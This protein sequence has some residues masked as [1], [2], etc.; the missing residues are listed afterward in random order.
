MSEYLPAYGMTRAKLD[1]LN[2][3]VCKVAG[4]T[5][6]RC[7]VNSYQD[8]ITAL[9]NLHLTWVIRANK[10]GFSVKVGGIGTARHQRL[11]IAI[12]QAI[13]GKEGA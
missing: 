13:T 7:P 12:C 10:S 3:K 9:E 11:C 1:R 5:V 4:L 2:T 8:A 6:E